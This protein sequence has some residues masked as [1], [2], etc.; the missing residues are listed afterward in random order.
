M[1]S[2]FNNISVPTEEGAWKTINQKEDIDYNI[3]ENSKQHFQQAQGTP[4]TIPPLVNIFSDGLDDSA[5]A[6][7]DGT[8]QIPTSFDTITTR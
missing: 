8:V 3:I 7:L 2:F 1:K 6:I 5:Q 4:P